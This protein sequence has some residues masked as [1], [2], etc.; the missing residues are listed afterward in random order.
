MSTLR[1][2]ICCKIIILYFLYIVFYLYWHF[3]LLPY[4]LPFYTLQL[5]C[6]HVCM[7]GG[8]SVCVCVGEREGEKVCLKIVI[9]NSYNI[10]M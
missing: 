6:M 2:S 4:Y 5:V 1:S 7:R 10:Y 8:V 9:M 3:T